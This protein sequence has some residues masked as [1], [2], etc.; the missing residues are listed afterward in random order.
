MMSLANYVDTSLKAISVMLYRKNSHYVTMSMLASDHEN[1][2]PRMQGLPT[3]IEQ[4][5]VEQFL[6]ANL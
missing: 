2:C 5:L 1:S 6:F 3:I 4:S